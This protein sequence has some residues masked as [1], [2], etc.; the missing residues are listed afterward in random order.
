MIRSSKDHALPRP[1]PPNSEAPQVSQERAEWDARTAAIIGPIL[2]NKHL[3]NT[4]AIFL[5]RNE[6][7]NLLLFW[8]TVCTLRDA[9][10]LAID[11]FNLRILHS[12]ILYDSY[13]RRGSPYEVAFTDAK[14]AEVLNALG[15]AHVSTIYGQLECLLR[16]EMAKYAAAFL[17]ETGEGLASPRSGGETDTEQSG[18]ANA[19]KP[20][21]S[22]QTLSSSSTT[23]TSA[24]RSTMGAGATL[25]NKRHARLLW[26]GNSESAIPV[27]GDGKNDQSANTS[28][29]DGVNQ[30]MGTTPSHS[31]TRS[32][33]KSPILSSSASGSRKGSPAPIS[34]VGWNQGAV[35]K[36]SVDPSVKKRHSS[37]AMRR[38]ISPL[39]HEGRLSPSSSSSSN[40]SP[41][42]FG[43]EKD[44]GGRKKRF[45]SKSN[46]AINKLAK[47][48][49]GDSDSGLDIMRS[50]LT[51]DLRE[52]RYFLVVYH[53]FLLFSPLLSLSLS[54]SLARAR[55]ERVC[56]TRQ[57]GS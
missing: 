18:A 39:S 48:G 34:K 14:R 56:F 54:L 33:S 2:A 35:S 36:V 24:H 28:G 26:R 50:R 29:E 10:M 8:S 44:M 38:A 46:N 12:K 53:L 6:Q 5:A 31:L 41:V 17:E 1:P 21:A 22:P 25:Q 23:T 27:E 43:I 19:G 11:V 30:K 32:A 47:K 4:F 9:P 51:S 57:T 45:R 13:L 37:E 55:G 3:Y 7:T 42:K 52:V 49:S 20:L 40:R 15:L 16:A